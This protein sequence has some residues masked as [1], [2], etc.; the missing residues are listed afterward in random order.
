MPYDEESTA[1]DRLTASLNPGDENESLADRGST[2]RR[3]RPRRQSERLWWLVHDQIGDRGD[4]C[5]DASLDQGARGHEVYILKCHGRFNQRWT[6]TD[7]TD[8][9][10]S[11]IGFDGR[12]LDITGARV[13]DGTSLQLWP[14]HLND[15]QKFERKGGTLVDKHSGKCLTT[16]FGNDRNPVYL[17]E[18]TGRREQQWGTFRDN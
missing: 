9:S 6:I 17:D 15:N 4:F 13:G 16:A 10:I 11:V 7:N 8:H 18:C 3:R 12:C 1:T 5:I 14:C 2:L